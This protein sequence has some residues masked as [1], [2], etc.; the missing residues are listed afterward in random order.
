LYTSIDKRNIE[1]DNTTVYSVVIPLC[2]I[3]PVLY[4]AAI[5]KK[6]KYITRHFIVEKES[7]CTKVPF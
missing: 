2:G 6:I 4:A 1:R 3:F 7:N 5:H